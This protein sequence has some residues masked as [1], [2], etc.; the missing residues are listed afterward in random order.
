MLSKIGFTN[1]SLFVTPVKLNNLK[2]KNIKS[3]ASQNRGIEYPNNIATVNDLSQKLFLLVAE[4]T[5][6]AVDNNN[7]NTNEIT[8]SITVYAAWSAI[9]VAIGIPIPACVLYQDLPKSNRSKS[10]I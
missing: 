5:P 3:L 7:D 4:T 2:D 10:L 6:I 9:I 8:F 1:A